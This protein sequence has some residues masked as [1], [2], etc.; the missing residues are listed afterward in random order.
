MIEG[1]S[2]S[3]MLEKRDKQKGSYYKL[4]WIPSH[5]ICLHI[6]VLNVIFFIRDFQH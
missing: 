2:S 6:T 3:L 1:L 5:A 4:Q